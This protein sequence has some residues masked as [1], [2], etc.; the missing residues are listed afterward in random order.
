MIY[1]RTIIKREKEGI[2]RLRT[3]ARA[4]A[5]KVA[6]L[7]K[8]K[9]GAKRVILFGS[10]VSKKYLHKRSDIDLLVEGIEKDDFLRAGFDASVIAKPFEVDIIPIETADKEILE[11]AKKEGVDL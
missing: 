10:L 6:E 11:R 9:Y 1:T 3:E 7:L 4:G 5:R 2:D 8:N